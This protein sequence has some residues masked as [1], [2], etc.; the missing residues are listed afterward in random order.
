[1]LLKNKLL[2]ISGAVTVYLKNDI[3]KI[4]EGIY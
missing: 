4:D 3:N 2:F 1:M